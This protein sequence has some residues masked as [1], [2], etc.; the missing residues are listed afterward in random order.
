M[1]TEWMTKR[2]GFLL[3]LTLSWVSAAAAPPP[4]AATPGVPMKWGLPEK[5]DPNA[6]YVIYLHGK[7]VEDQG[8]AAV[9]PEFGPYRFQGIVDS[10]KTKGLVVI[11]ETRP[12][13]TDAAKFAKRVVQQVRVLIAKGV[14]AEHITVIGASKGA[15]IA[16]LVSDQV[17]TLGVR[18]VLLAI[19]NQQTLEGWKN[20]SV[21]VKGAVLS[22]YDFKDSI[23]GSCQDLFTRCAPDL[24]DHHEIEVKLGKGHGLLYEPFPEWIEPAVQWARPEA[25]P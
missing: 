1:P 2:I 17:G 4:P 9:S 5:I 24:T 11:S 23:A 15:G 12:K 10:F 8:P 3:A 19:C 25:R 18:T 22:I 6:Y 14:P 21:C 7:I 20:A 16:L 13:G